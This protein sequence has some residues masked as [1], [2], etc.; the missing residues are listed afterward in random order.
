MGDQQRHD[1]ARQLAA[2]ERTIDE[3]LAAYDRTVEDFPQDAFARNGRAETLRAMGR[4]DEAL[5]AYDR[6]VEDFPQ[7]AVA[8]TGYAVVLGE[9]GRF[10]EARET[11]KD[12]E[13]NPRTS[14]DWVAVH[15]L[16][17]IDSKEGTTNALAQR[18]ERF[19]VQCPFPAQRLYFETTLAVVRIALRRTLE[20]RRDLKAIAARPGLVPEERAAMTLMEAHAEAADGDLNAARQTLA[21][22]S[23][24][25]PFEHFRL[26]RLKQE[27]ERHFGVGSVPAPTR[28]DE[29]AASEKKLIRLEMDFWFDRT[30][31]ASAMRRA[32]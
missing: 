29:V 10:D 17:M 22:V 9:L 13:L 16:C 15:I 30:T 32:A 19:A 25:I 14:Q 26:R 6:T 5:A 8:R 11:L 20:A 12:V 2:Y 18:L 28:A 27:I 7:N 23:N 1:V 3:A 24:V 4:L 21:A 31:E